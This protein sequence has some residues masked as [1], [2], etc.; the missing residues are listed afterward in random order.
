MVSKNNREMIQ[1]HGGQNEPKYALRRL[2]IGVAS[3]LLGTT[4]FMAGSHQVAHADT[5]TEGDQETTPLTTK[6]SA[7]PQDQT[8][9]ANQVTLCPATTSAPKLTHSTNQQPLRDQLTTVQPQTQSAT[10]AATNRANQSVDLTK[11]QYES[12]DNGINLTGYT[13]DTTQIVIPNNVDFQQAGKLTNGQTV[14]ITK[15]VIARLLGANPTTLAVSTTGDGKVIASGSDWSGAFSKQYVYE[16]GTIAPNKLTTLDLANLDTSQITN[17]H[18]MFSGYPHQALQTITGLDH[19]DV[20]HVTDMSN[21][22]NGDDALQ[23]VDDLTNW[24]VSQVTNMSQMFDHTAMS[25]VGNLTNWQVDKVTNMADMFANTKLQSVGLLNNWQVNQVADMSGMFLH[26]AITAI[27]N[28][29]RWQVGNVQDMSRM[30][31]GSALQDLDL[32][33][34]NVSQ[35]RDFSY[36]FFQSALN[37]IGALTHWNVAKAT[38]LT[39]M[40]AQTQLPD[41]GNL[42]QWQVGKVTDMGAMFSNSQMTNVGKL[43]DWDVA[44][45]TKMD[46]MFDASALTNLDLSKWNVASVTTM[47]NM[48]YN[49]QLTNLGD[50]SNWNVANVTNFSSMFGQSQLPSINISNWDFGKAVHTTEPLQGVAKM[51]ANNQ[52]P[53]VIIAN[54]LK[55]VPTTF[56]VADFNSA[57]QPHSSHLVV[58]TNNA[59][60]LGLKDRQIPNQLT[61]QDQQQTVGTDDAP[62]FYQSNGSA[63]AHAIVLKQI[64]DQAAAFLKNHSAYNGY[65]IANEAQLSP[66]ELA[67]A[68]LQLTKAPQKVRVLGYDDVTKQAI[69]K[70]NADS[71]DQKLDSTI[72]QLIN[73]LKARH[74]VFAN[75]VTI[76]ENGENYPFELLMVTIDGQTQVPTYYVHF[77]HATKKSTEIKTVKQS[78]HYVFADGQTAAPDH[79]QAVT[80]T[81]TNTT[82]LVTGVTTDG[83]WSHGGNYTFAVVTSPAIAG[84]MPSQSEI[85]SQA[86]TP[87]NADIVAKV[88]Y[89]KNHP[90]TPDKP[91]P[92]QPKPGQPGHQPLPGGHDQP[93]TPVNHEQLLT[94]ANTTTARQQATKTKQL[95]QTGTDHGEAMIALGLV[96]LMS[97]LGLGCKKRA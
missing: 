89:T 32:T 76:G 68:K 53:Q 30:F 35:V 80:F 91:T 19:W 1:R 9:D 78:I 11:W 84:Y 47:A 79:T 18:D 44:K 20:S 56:N 23:N 34:W 37:K 69:P 92:E 17:M 3:V 40:F 29:A 81:R 52:V 66:V 61:Y 71:D 26:S 4:V 77:T 45:V 14:Q 85:A 75:K 86:V 50:L 49:S 42:D 94:S 39:F 97:L 36:M 7:T 27:G 2:S 93:Q 59:T 95:P 31:E 54:N 82:D 8:Q 22:F 15:D 62:T 64:Q 72:K 16:N 38:N 41:I 21:L 46:A 70:A 5:Q 12:T 88:V 90:A 43:A 87:T 58:I 25:S 13:G 74:Y 96:T 57:H 65:T 60:L 67:N 83:T 10:P 33:S 24:N 28:L 63:D 55:N 73:D 48:F 6:Q 51:F